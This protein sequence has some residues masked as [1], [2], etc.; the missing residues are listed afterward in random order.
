MDTMM[1]QG[2]RGLMAG[3]TLAVLAGPARGADID[4]VVTIKPVHA[5]VAA[6]MDGVAV[7]KLLVDG[8][9]S[10][11]TYALKP[12]DAAALNQANLF[13]RVSEDLE[14]FTRKAVKSLPK[15]VTVVTLSTVKGLKLLSQ[16]EGGAFEGHG[17][18]KG[19]GHGHGHA[20]S[21]GLDGH[22][23]LDPANAKI[24]ADRVAEVLSARLPAR[25][26]TFA[27]NAAAL[28]TRIDAL[29]AELAA[30]LAPAKGK[31]FVVFHD[32]YQY[33]E[34]RYGLTAA[35]SITVNP[36]VPPSAKR[37]TQLR[38][39]VQQLGAVCVL[40][41]PQF[42]AK[43]VSAIADGTSARLGEIDPE[44]ARLQAGPE[45]YFTLMRN[46]A[47]SLRDCLGVT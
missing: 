32:A 33:F 4:V 39:K 5:L 3:L 41:E 38:A 28:R 25:A 31:P 21:A 35:G 12:S 45:L 1:R 22:I 16:R 19:H 9:A 29:D 18:D 23:W 42:D 14:P 30:A 2:L 11:H 10:P 6:V 20:K 47:R 24:I 8:A 34:Q 46:L 13:I 36:E 17:H 40:R 37:L 27:R 7:P 43:V 15:S 44:G 26:E